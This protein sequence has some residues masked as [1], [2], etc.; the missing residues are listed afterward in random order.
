MGELSH[1]GV[2]YATTRAVTDK[3][4]RAVVE[5]VD[6]AQECRLRSLTGVLGCSASDRLDIRYLVENRMRKITHMTSGTQ[7]RTRC[8]VRYLVREPH[9]SCIDVPL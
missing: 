3:R 6:E 5:L 4:Q 2:E 9:A 7:A 8:V 1:V